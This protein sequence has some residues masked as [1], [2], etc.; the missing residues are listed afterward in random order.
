MKN[1]KQI[2]NDY[3][4]KGLNNES[5]YKKYDLKR[6]KQS[7]SQERVYESLPE[8]PTDSICPHCEEKMVAKFVSKSAGLFLDRRG[9]LCSE[10]NIHELVE[11]EQ[12]QSHTLEYAPHSYGRAYI[13]SEGY[14]VSAP[15]CPFCGHLQSTYCDC[16]NCSQTKIVNSIRAAE[17]VYAELESRQKYTVDDLTCSDILIFLTH[18]NDG[19]ST[20]NSNLP[21]YYLQSDNVLDK[22]L[23]LFLLGALDI[24]RTHSPAG[25]KMT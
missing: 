4:L 7:Y 14:R 24:D 22:S 12:S 17:T 21:D 23:A 18:L 25:I 3:Y 19:S 11:Q 13:T 6:T 5:I 15:E 20:P 1:W 2:A 9:L 10:P 16:S 8:Y